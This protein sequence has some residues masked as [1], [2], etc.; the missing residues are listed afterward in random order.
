MVWSIHCSWSTGICNNT[1]LKDNN[2]VGHQDSCKITYIMKAGY[3]SSLKKPTQYNSAT[4]G[5]ANKH[6]VPII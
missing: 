2:E 5:T 3:T 1:N 4:Q 6:R